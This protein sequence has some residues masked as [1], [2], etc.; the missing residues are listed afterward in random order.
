MTK[1]ILIVVDTKK[2]IIGKLSEAIIKYNPHFEFS[3]YALHPR[4][5][6]ENIEDFK[7]EVKKFEP[8]VIHFQYYRSCSQALDLWPELKDYK[9]ILTHHNQK[10]KAV[11]HRQW[12]KSGVDHL[13]CHTDR[14]KD[15]LRENGED[16]K[17]VT[18][19]QHGLDLDYFTFSSD[20]PEHVRIGYVGRIVPWKGLLEIC[21]AARDLKLKVLLMGVIDKP[22]YWKQVDEYNDVLDMSYYN[23]SDKERIDAY[24]HMTIYIGN[25]VDGFEEGPMG[26]LEAWASGVP[27]IT[28]NTGEARDLAIK[29]NSIVIPFK[30]EEG[31]YEALK[32]AIKRLLDDKELRNKL[33]KH[34]WETIRNMSEEKM[35]RA[36]SSL[37]YKVGGKRKPLVSVIIPATY[38]RFEQVQKIIIDLETKQ[39]YRNFEAIVIWDEENLDGMKPLA[40]IIIPLKQLVT[41]RKGYNLAMARNM[42]IVEAEGDF[43][44]F[45]DV[46][47]CPEPDAIKEFMEAS[48]IPA[49]TALWMFGDKGGGKRNFVENFSFVERIEVIKLGMM[50]ERLDRYGG[51]SQ[52]IRTRWRLQRNAFFFVEDAKAKEMKSSRMSTDRRRDITK[53]KIK[54]FKIYKHVIF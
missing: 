41:E 18:I 34:G 54:L 8:D 53:S 10:D 29:R 19:I 26:L 48:T 43:I 15:M 20:E 44:M 28:T 16:W 31:S 21:R 47:F 27:V 49:D 6:K 32:K 37:Y 7:K 45:N 40:S 23:C 36:Y 2:W 42:G 3:Y 11:C 17:S 14:C 38:E 9:I 39:T 4:S 1:K 35:A 25:S 52:D 12:Q 22:D 13:V 51:L 46:R 24:R 5:V 50:N 33:R 30:D